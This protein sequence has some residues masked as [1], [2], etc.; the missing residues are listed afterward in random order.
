MEG[1]EKMKRILRLLLVPLVTLAFAGASVAQSTPTTPA[2]PAGPAKPA[3]KKREAGQKTT[4]V[5]GE[6][7]SV[8]AKA[9]TLKIKTKDKELSLAATSKETK[10]ALGKVKVGDTVRVAYTE[11]EGKLILS[12]V[13]K[14]RIRAQ[15][16]PSEKKEETKP[17]K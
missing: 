8:D 2:Q 17:A 1:G 6:L 16:K 14:A 13:N 15:A 7:V 12:S 9:G 10:S 3:Q 5:R 11:K 4:R